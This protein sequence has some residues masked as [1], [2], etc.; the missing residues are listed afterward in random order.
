[1][2]LFVF[3]IEEND[4]GASLADKATMLHQYVYVQSEKELN[5]F[6][7]EEDFIKKLLLE[8]FEPNF[9]QTSR[10]I[11]MTKLL[12]RYYGVFVEMSGTEYNIQ[13]YQQN[14]IKI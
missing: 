11:V 3:E 8:V 10:K 6:D 4:L 12:G 1:M 9:V 2:N 7:I 13:F 14:T 5:D